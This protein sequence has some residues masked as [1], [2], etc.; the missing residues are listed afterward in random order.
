MQTAE[1]EATVS[2]ENL[3]RAGSKDDVEAMLDALHPDELL[4]EVYLLAP[5]DQ[6]RLLTLLSPER[7]AAL[8]EVVSDS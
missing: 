5:D 6:R 8:L 4:H 1:E 7:A 3:V 2:L